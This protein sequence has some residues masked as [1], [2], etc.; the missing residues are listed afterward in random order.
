M[1]IRRPTVEAAMPQ[2][3]SSETHDSVNATAVLNELLSRAG[4]AADMPQDALRAIQSAGDSARVSVAQDSPHTLSAARYIRSIRGID[5]DY[6]AI[7]RDPDISPSPADYM[8][9][10]LM[11]RIAELENR[12]HRAGEYLAESAILRCRRCRGYPALSAQCE[13]MTRCVAHDWAEE[14]RRILGAERFMSLHEQSEFLTI[15]HPNGPEERHFEAP[16]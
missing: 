15:P 3:G 7:R 4:V 6:L 12:L 16:F 14:A 5:P 11:S 2:S 13:S 9:N 8:A 1:P 10:Q